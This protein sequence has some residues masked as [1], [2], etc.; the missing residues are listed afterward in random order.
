MKGSQKWGTPQNGV[1][2]AV[3]FKASLE[4]LVLL[5]RKFCESYLSSMDRGRVRGFCF[6]SKDR[7]TERGTV[8]IKRVKLG[9]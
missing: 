6:A 1:L 4:S 2:M 7:V 3:V 5:G 9:I 8:V